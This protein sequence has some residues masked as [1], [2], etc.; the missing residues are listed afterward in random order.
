VILARQILLHDDL[1]RI[2][3]IFF[4]VAH[5]L[6]L[7]FDKVIFRQYLSERPQDLL[8]VA[9]IFVAPPLRVFN[10]LCVLDT[11]GAAAV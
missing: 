4:D 1:K 8:L 10:G 11:I 3:L 6:I 7:D 5:N 9:Q 2:A